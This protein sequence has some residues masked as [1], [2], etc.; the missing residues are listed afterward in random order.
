MQT[1][2]EFKKAIDNLGEKHFQLDYIITHTAPEETMNIF[3]PFHEEEK[4]L[5]NFLE[6]VRGKTSISICILDVYT[7]RKI[8]GEVRLFYGKKQEI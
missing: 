3:H 8:F 1:D 2:V 7:E 6:W 4:P 5:N